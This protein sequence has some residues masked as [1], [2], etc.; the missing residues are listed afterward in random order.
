MDAG[1]RRLQEFRKD[2]GRD[3][4]RAEDQEG[5][6]KAGMVGPARALLSQI[7]DQETESEQEQAETTGEENVG[8]GPELL[9]DGE[10]EIP[11]AT[12]KNSTDA[13]GG[14]SGGLRFQCALCA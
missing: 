13:G 9:V 3:G 12:Q 6:E 2:V 5:T 7:D 4:V 8:A 1:E 14:Y 10:R 11:E